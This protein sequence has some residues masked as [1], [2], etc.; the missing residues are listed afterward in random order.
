M[1][2]TIDLLKRDSGVTA[3]RSQGVIEYSLMETFMTLHNSR[4]RLIYDKDIDK[5]GVLKKIAAN[6]YY[7]YQKSKSMMFVA[8]RDFVLIHHLHLVSQWI[9]LS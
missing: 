9:L 7:I 6:T 4:Y 2:V 5:A 8:S 3:M 1:G